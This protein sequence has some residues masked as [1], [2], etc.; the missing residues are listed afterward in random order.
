MDHGAT[1]THPAEVTSMQAL[2][3]IIRRQDLAT[4]ESPAEFGEHVGNP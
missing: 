3:Q 2:R 1:L 4:L